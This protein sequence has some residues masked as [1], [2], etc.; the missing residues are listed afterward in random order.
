M[1]KYLILIAI[2]IG[3]PGP[4]L[5]LS[6]SWTGVH[7]DHDLPI[8]GILIFGSGIVAAAFLLSWAGEALQKDLSGAFAFALVAIVALLPEYAVEALLAWDAGANPEDSVIVGRVA[9]NVT[10]ANRLLIGF[11]W[12]A[13]ALMSWL[14]IRKQLEIGNSLRL[15][16]S[17]LTIATILSFLLFFM[18]EASIYLGGVLVV[19][20]AAYLIATSRS[21]HEEPDLHG[22]A[23]VIGSLDFKLRRLSIIGLFVFLQV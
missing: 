6:S 5:W 9:A 7:L 21:H 14:R 11:G 17:V 1:N 4:L 18:G 8:A 22:P 3:L 19:I 16:L 10:G 12:S 15:E 13:V 20:Y 23:A 2:I